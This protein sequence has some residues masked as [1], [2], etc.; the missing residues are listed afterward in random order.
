MTVS[1]TTSR[2]SYAGN[3]ATTAFNVPFYFLAD[4]DLVV[5]RT[6]SGIDTTLVL[7]TDYTVTGAGVPAGGTVTTTTAPAVGSTLTIYRDPPATQPVD[8]QPNDAFPAETHERALDRVT[9][10][11]QRDRDLITRSVRLPDGDAS[12][13][14]VVLPAPSGGKL[15][16]WNIGGTAIDNID[17]GTLGALVT[18]GTAYFDTFTGNGSTTAFTL[19]ANP[20]SLNNLI[21]AVNGLVQRPTTNYT[22]T[23][24]TLNFVSAPA[25]GATISV[26]Y[27]GGLPTTY[28][29]A[30]NVTVSPSTA[31]M[32]LSDGTRQMVYTPATPTS[33]LNFV[34]AT[35]VAFQQNGS[36]WL[37]I[38]TTR[39]VTFAAPVSGITATFNAVS[40]AN[41]VNFV[42]AGSS[43]ASAVWT[44]GNTGN[45]QWNI[46]VGQQATGVFSIRDNTAAAYRMQIA[47][48]GVT[49]FN[50]GV[51]TPEVV[52]TF[53]ATAMTV[54]CSLSNV[55][56]TTFTAN[57]TTAPTISN[58]TDGQ[59]INWFITQD[60]T[61]SRTMTWPT[62]FKWPGGSA[63]ILSTA[64]N[65]VDLVVATYRSTTGFWY[66][67]LQKGFA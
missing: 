32:T 29:G 28:S 27:V 1:S 45:R 25:N 31:A 16:G 61:G 56:R 40:A 43:Y 19:S 18:Y 14:S 8:Y 47:T 66:V 34:P 13:A 39:Q 23:G 36:N 60:A 48:N 64:A 59:T 7:N 30:I 37:S 65:S 52:V 3:G 62:S 15:L 55:F 50:G 9:M 53:S 67:N 46:A 21:V 26:Q 33:T 20:G 35:A 63:G 6:T 44:D 57:V 54:D 12:G 10:L 42:G 11:V 5:I 41:A 49:T 2:T 4:A 58:P 38:S 17:A 22:Y 24:T 51:A